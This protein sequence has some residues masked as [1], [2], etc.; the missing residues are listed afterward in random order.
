MSIFQKILKLVIV[1]TLMTYPLESFSQSSDIDPLAKPLFT[2]S[3]WSVYTSKNQ[4]QCWLASKPKKSVNT[5]DGKVVVVNRGKSYLW[6]SFWAE[7][8]D[9][10]QVSF[11]GGY[12]YNP[13]EVLDFNIDNTKFDLGVPPEGDYPEYTFNFAWA[14]DAKADK[15][16]ITAM[17]RGSTAIITGFS[18]RGTK[19]RDTFSLMGFT[20]ALKDAEK[21]CP[22]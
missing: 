6:V 8:K 11:T 4:K 21:R 19:T 17:K 5:K 9:R 15:E 12:P 22:E 10:G 1:A 13:G 7:T 20:A 18:K 16:I 3:D 14:G 2:Q